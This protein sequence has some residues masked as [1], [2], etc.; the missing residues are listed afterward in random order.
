MVVSLTSVQ[1]Y[2]THL[3]RPIMVAAAG[4]LTM[5]VS[6]PILDL[7]RMGIKES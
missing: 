2:E 4:V 6:A 5:K 3:Q 1:F 7:P